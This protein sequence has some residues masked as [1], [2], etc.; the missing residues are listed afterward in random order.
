MKAILYSS[1]A[2]PIWVYHLC[3]NAAENVFFIIL[4]CCLV[5]QLLLPLSILPLFYYWIYSTFSNIEVIV[6]WQSKT[7]RWQISITSSATDTRTWFLR[8]L[9]TPALDSILP[10]FCAFPL[11]T[12]LVLFLLLCK[13]LFTLDV[14]DIKSYVW[15][16]ITIVHHVFCIKETE[17]LLQLLLHVYGYVP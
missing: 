10:C 12:L 17:L 5:F 7:Y 2:R 13:H 8:T 3:V 16:G 15:Q 1:S 11:L 9:K 4:L 6:H 14:H